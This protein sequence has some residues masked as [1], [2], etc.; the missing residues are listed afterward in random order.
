MPPMSSTTVR[1]QRIATARRVVVKVGTNSI[2]G[3]NG[4]LDH[5][6]LGDFARQIADVIHQGRE[7]ILVASGAVGAGLAELDL[8]GRPRE[9]PMLQATAAVGQGRLMQAFYE[10]FGGHD[11]KVA[12]VLVTRDAFEDRRRYLNIRNTLT[13]LAGLHVLPILNENDA[14]AVD[15]I[16]YGTDVF[17]A[18]FGDN[19]TIAAH[20]ANMLDA[21]VLILLSNVDGVLDGGAVI[22]VIEQVNDDALSVV[23]ATRSKLGSGGMGS[24]MKA[25]GMVTSAG[26]V[27][28]IANSRTRDIIP[29][30][31]AGEQLGTV[32]IPALRR[33]SSRRRW[34]GQTSHSSGKILVDSGAAAALRQR[35]K[36]L[37]PSGIVAV[38]GS[39]ARGAVVDILD[40]AGQSVARGVTNFSAA[41]IDRVKGMKSADITRLTLLGD[42]AA[43]EV[44]H[45]NNMTMTNGQ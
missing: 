3:E 20:V 18:R 23:S 32:F 31:L 33:M 14:V 19:D 17:S 2:T 29:R 8:P 41:D 35:G 4:R 39:F 24:K 13:T 7:I 26:N 22:D 1:Q 38:S 36:S 45:R 30:L 11:V 34:I 21:Q 27:A 5:K 10:A 40:P 28:V 44:V 37:L 12:Q 25:A 9:L 42:N 15:E 16:R 43:T 6:V